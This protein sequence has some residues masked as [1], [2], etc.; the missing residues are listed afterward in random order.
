MTAMVVN[1]F[2]ELVK[3]RCACCNDL[4][5]HDVWFACD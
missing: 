3:A 1:C 5:A 4:M 2:Y